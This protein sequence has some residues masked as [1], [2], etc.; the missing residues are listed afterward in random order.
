MKIMFEDLLSELKTMGISFSLEGEQLRVHSSN[1]PLTTESIEKIKLHKDKL[2][3]LLKKENN[4]DI[5]IPYV[6]RCKNNVY[7]TLSS[8]QE[9]LWVLHKFNDE[10]FC[11]YNEALLFKIDGTISIAALNKAMNAII[12][13]HEILRTI[14]ISSANKGLC[15]KVLTNV[16]CTIVMESSDK[17][18]FGK[19]VEKYISTPFDLSTW[20]LLRVHLICVGESE[21]R[22]LFVLH[23]IIIDGASLRILCNE[24][25]EI[26]NSI[27]DG[28]FADLPNLPIQYLD[29]SFWQKDLIKTQGYKDK[30]NYWKNHL[31]GYQ[32]LDLSFNKKRRQRFTYKGAKYRFNLSKTVSCGISKLA[33]QEKTTLFNVMLSGLCILLSKYCR[34]DDILIG[35]PMLNRQNKALNNLLGFFTNTVVLRNHVDNNLSFKKFLNNVKLNTLNAYENQS[36]SFEHVV[37]NMNAERDLSRNPIVQI[38]LFV[39][40]ETSQPKLQLRNLDVNLIEPHSH[41]IA[42]FDLTMG[43][44]E[45]DDMLSISFEY[46]TDL[47]NEQ[48]IEILSNHLE[49][50]F[51]EVTVFPEQAIK[52]LSI[53]NDKDSH[54]MLVD[55]NSHYK[56]YPI[57]ATLHD[58]FIKQVHRTPDAIAVKCGQDTLTYKDLD[59][60]STKLALYIQERYKVLYGKVMTADTLIGLCVDRSLDTIISILAIL[61]AGGAYV[62][63]DPMYPAERIKYIIS[64]CKAVLMIT[65]RKI[66]EAVPELHTLNQ[67]KLL[68]LDDKNVAKEIADQKCINF[69]ELLSNKDPYSLAY[70][71][72]TSGSTGKP[73]GVLLPHI[74]VLK[75]FSAALEHYR[76]GVDDVWT[77]FHSMAFDFSVWEIWGALL[78]GGKII[79]VPYDISRDSKE[80]YELVKRENVT[81]LNQTPSAFQNFIDVD[82]N[83]Q[84]KIES[85]R[86]VIFGGEALNIE[87]L[88]NWWVSHDDR[89]PLLVNMYGIT[90]TTVHVTF[91]ALSYSDLEGNHHGRIGIPLKNSRVYVLDEQNGLCPIGIPGEL[92]IGGDGLARGYLNRDELTA[93]RFIKNPFA[94]QIG[95]PIS[96]RLYKTGD[97]VRWLPDGRLEYI[98]RTDLQVKLRGFR[99]ELGE[100][101][102]MLNKHAAVKQAVVILREDDDRRYLV[103]YYVISA[104]VAEPGMEILLSYLREHLP[105]Y[106]VP[107]MLIKLN[108]IPLTGNGKIDKALLPKPRIE[109]I[110]TSYSSPMNEREHMA[111]KIWSEFLGI[112]SSK[113][114][115]T[116]NYFQLGGNSL[117]VMRM[118]S[119]IKKKIGI[120]ISISEFLRAPT[121]RAMTKVIDECLSN[122]N[123]YIQKIKNIILSDLLL[124]ESIKPLDIVN[125]DVFK[126]RKILITGATG[127]LGSYLV[128]ELHKVMGVQLYCLVRDASKEKAKA[129]LY[130]AFCK[131]KLGHLSGA[132]NIKVVHGDFESLNLGLSE[133]NYDYLCKNIDVIYHNGA[134]VH[135]LYDY[136]RMRIANVISTGEMLKLATTGKNKAVHFISTVSVN[137]FDIRKNLNSPKLN[138]SFLELNGYLL[139]KWVSEQLI[140]QASKRGI[141][142]RIYRPG[143]ITGDSKTGFCIPEYNHTLLRIKGFIQL[144]RAYYDDDELLEMMPVDILA[145]K[146]VTSSLDKKSEMILNLDNPEKIKFSEYVQKFVDSHYKIDKIDSLLVWRKV[147]NQL[148]EDNVLYSLK[149]FYEYDGSNKYT[150]LSA[151]SGLK[152]EAMDYQYLISKQIKY[153]QGSGFIPIPA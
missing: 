45:Q 7:P 121:I 37:S 35:A 127:F 25:S 16:T 64:D 71:I 145:N 91:Q 150:Q 102:S 137:G 100:I 3:S 38:I 73:K 49:K 92:H 22:L 66:L 152:N 117:S 75:L 138:F 41:H 30:V 99:I 118:I 101:E 105:E 111:T 128:N 78:Y 134:L 97:L 34:Q 84:Q 123:E 133:E 6:R 72:Y 113:I 18:S 81:I 68:I 42:K 8:S 57:T 85:L 10:D 61:K 76:F 46:S 13:R 126:P 120:D 122:G 135:H 129:K 53:T 4:G 28:R 59:A 79:I 139:T 96:D 115:V 51:R 108:S 107:T 87:M 9:S 63:I 17:A 54:R 44:F 62:P 11:A 1:G 33:K 29:Y 55:W 23:H 70:V 47:F 136:E 93:E 144:G 67:E 98:G 15:Q 116:E 58:E 149:A 14:I 82:M 43:V 95:L 50:I 60:E 20:P 125:N 26:Y 131:N 56:N 21:Y 124:P 48:S 103:G 153:L 94:E 2:I 24:L 31:A 143:N 12:N 40:N 77:M 52:S 119:E 80:F 130:A 19:L 5:E 147:I 114:S 27:I 89:S 90:E 39:V 104:G 65:Q 106:M 32:D 146:I 142:A 109:E 141:M 132:S 110:S 86:H 140:M 88:K 83:T 148:G 112:E 36:V 69:E 151:S 74:N